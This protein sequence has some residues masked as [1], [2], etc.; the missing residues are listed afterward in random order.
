MSF[1]RLVREV[2]QEI[3]PDIQFQANALMPKDMQLV[4]RIK[5]K[6]S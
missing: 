1:Q 4:R 3:R 2:T 5:G 6:K